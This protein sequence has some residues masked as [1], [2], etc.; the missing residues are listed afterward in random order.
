MPP[1]PP[2]LESWDPESRL[3]QGTSG[4]APGARVRSDNLLLELNAWLGLARA[5]AHSAR[6]QTILLALQTDLQRMAQRPPVPSGH[7][8]SAF[9][10]E[11][12]DWLNETWA[13][14]ER[15]PPAR[16]SSELPGDTVSGAIL[17]LASIVARR[18]GD[19]LR[20]EAQMDPTA[21]GYLDRLPGLLFTLAR[22]EEAQADPPR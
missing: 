17:D 21:Q 8:L 5:C 12:V 15:D 20:M 22:Y 13:T 14:L 16:G 11:R 3:Q 9:P 6:V 10:A 18:L 7:S 2:E 19:R 1:Y 4:L